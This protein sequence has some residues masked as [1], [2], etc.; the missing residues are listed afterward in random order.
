MK[1]VV[2]NGS[3]KGE[4]SVTRQYVLLLE[5]TFHE[6]Q[7]VVLPVAQQ[8]GKLAKDAAA[9]NAVIEEVRSADGVVS[10]RFRRRSIL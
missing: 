1:I 9:F 3:P 6:H 2:L 4:V 8:I 5:K 7:F 10:P